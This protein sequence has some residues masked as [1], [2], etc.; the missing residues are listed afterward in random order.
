[1]KLD[2]NTPAEI[3]VTVST[4]EGFPH[5]PLLLAVCSS[6]MFAFLQERDIVEACLA[7]C[8]L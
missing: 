4:A 1:M 5:G 7:Y 6:T 2:Q 3:P 8:T